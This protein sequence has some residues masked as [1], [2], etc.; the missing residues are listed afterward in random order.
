MGRLEEATIADLQAAM[1]AGD[2]TARALVELYLERIELLDRSGPRLGAV[3]EVNPDAWDIARDLDRERRA[4]GPRGPLHG[5]PVLV[6]DNIDTGDRMQTTAGSVALAGPPAPED[7]TVVRRLREAGAVIL[8]KTNLS[9]WANFRSTRSVSGWSAR[10]GQ[11]RNPYALDRS[12]SGSSSGSAAAVAANLCAAA[13]GTETDGSIVSPS[14]ACGVV[15]LKPTVGLTSRYGVVPISHTQDTVGPHARTVADAAAVLGALAGVDP[16]DPATAA[17][18]ARAHRDYTAFLDEGGLRGAR[19]GV[20]RGPY[21]GLH[22]KVDRVFEEALRAL[23]EA[24]A[25]LV[26]PADLPGG[27]E[28][29]TDRSELEVLLY[30]FKHGLEAYLRRRPDVPVRTLADLITFNERHAAAELV[31][32]GQELLEQAAA[33]GGLDDPAYREA[34]ERSRRLGRE[35]IDGALSRYGV[36]ALVAP[37]GAPAWVIDTV[38]GDPRGSVFGSSGPAA[39]AGY[40]LIT[41]PMGFVQGLPVGITFMGTAWSEPTLI[42]LAHA[43]ERFTRAR[44]PPRFPPGAG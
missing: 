43:F 12:P 29:R 5:I 3:V 9:E 41:V 7:A 25:E 24:G 20:V 42:R 19:I 35:A 39:R 37:S 27:D 23:R 26:D 33:R 21:A 28:L 15:G 6:K 2:L 13:L 44:R 22:P 18:A 14:H 17:A 34:L 8:G 31:Y 1:E 30:E 40:P 16:A 32:F 10:G 36:E 4:R 38:N 11:T